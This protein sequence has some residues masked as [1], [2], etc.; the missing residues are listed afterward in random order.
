MSPDPG[1]SSEEKMVIDGT[2]QFDVQHVSTLC[3]LLSS[4][5]KTKPMRV[6]TVYMPPQILLLLLLNT[7]HPITYNMVQ[8]DTP[9]TLKPLKDISDS[10]G[11]FTPCRFNLREVVKSHKAKDRDSEVLSSGLQGE[12]EMQSHSK[13]HA[14]P[15]FE[16]YS[17]TIRVL[18]H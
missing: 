9:I 3:S 12:T 10:G 6:H 5:G 1:P 13:G 2:K 7:H 16:H 8:L 11:V 4:I 14:E 18:N 15:E 17:V